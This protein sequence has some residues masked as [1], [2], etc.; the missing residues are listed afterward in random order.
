MPCQA[1]DSKNNY[2]TQ[3]FAVDWLSPSPTCHLLNDR[4]PDFCPVLN[5][6]TSTSATSASVLLLKDP[7]DPI[8][9]FLA[10][11][12]LFL[13]ALVGQ[14]LPLQAKWVLQFRKDWLH[15]LRDMF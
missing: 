1:F 4:G 3:G 13:A 9:R 8:F 14:L 6:H 11:R 5:E 7:C 15:F 12:T 2:L 10:T